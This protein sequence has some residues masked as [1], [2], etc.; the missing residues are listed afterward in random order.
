MHAHD[1]VHRDLKPDVSECHPT[2]KQSGKLTISCLKNILVQQPGPSWWVKIAD[3]GFSKRAKAD[4]EAADTYCYSP[5]FS[6]PEQRDIYS[7]E[8]CSHATDI[9]ATG[10]VTYLLLSGNLA[11]PT[12]R[13][14]RNY[15][16]PDDERYEVDRLCGPLING[17]VSPDG[18][19]FVLKLLRPHPTNRPEARLCLEDSWAAPVSPIPADSVISH[20]T[21]D[22]ANTATLGGFWGMLPL[23]TPAWLGQGTAEQNDKLAEQETKEEQPPGLVRKPSDATSGHRTL[24]SNA[25]DASRPMVSV[26]EG[27]QPE[28]LAQSGQRKTR[29]FT[30]QISA[31]PHHSLTRSQHVRIRPSYPPGPYETPLAVQGRAVST[32]TQP[33]NILEPYPTRPP[34]PYEMRFTNQDRAFTMP[35]QAQNTYG[36]ET[37]HPPQQRDSGYQSS[38]P[39]HMSPK[40]T[41]NHD[42]W[43]GVAELPAIET[44]YRTQSG[45][46]MA[47]VR[48]GS[49]MDR[50]GTGVGASVSNRHPQFTSSPR[51]SIDGPMPDCQPRTAPHV[52][53]MR[54]TPS[55]RYMIDVPM[56]VHQPRAA[57]HVQNMRDTPSPRYPIDGPT[58]NCQPRAAPHVQSMWDTPSPRYSMP[59]WQPHATPHFHSMQDTPSPKG[60]FDSLMPGFQPRAA[61]HVQ[62]MQGT[63]SPK[64]SFDNLSPGP[65]P[66][67]ARR[68]R[69]RVSVS[70]R[71]SAIQWQEQIQVGLSSRSVMA[72]TLCENGKYG[73]SWSQ[74]GILRL[75]SPQDGQRRG[76]FEIKDVKSLLFSPGSN[77]LAVRTKQDLEMYMMREYPFRLI[78]RVPINGDHA[79]EQP[80]ASECLF[81]RD[82]QRIAVP[83]ARKGGMQLINTAD[84]IVFEK[85]KSSGT[86]V[87]S[88]AISKDL[89]SLAVGLDDNTVKI[90]D[91]PGYTERHTLH[92][93]AWSL[94]QVTR[95]AYSDTGLLAASSTSGI[96]KIWDEAGHTV[97]SIPQGCRLLDCAFCPTPGSNL[98]VTADDGG[99]IRFFNSTDAEVYPNHYVQHKEYGPVLR[100]LFSPDGTFGVSCGYKTIE[101]WHTATATVL[102]RSQPQSNEGYGVRAC[103][104]PTSLNILAFALE[105]GVQLLDLGSLRARI[106]S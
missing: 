4:S 23:L 17:K 2:R 64:G 40:P 103:F 76:Q 47:D 81:S 91:L 46:N 69:S 70:P 99:C 59:D 31:V 66:H 100:V 25:G 51:E 26:R 8:R 38:S 50:W 77:I 35:T 44:P 13:D 53:S 105:T 9:F 71:S 48:S 41:E 39:L 57:P 16:D 95:V 67:T 106:P 21:S 56:P 62:S 68:I 5:G 42:A 84:G 28:T 32:P 61:P 27:P 85:L 10:L 24:T 75:W 43:T 104:S 12:I 87:T 22:T 98:V 49:P 45:N 34:K 52:Q 89:H 80:F 92:H 6:A 94:A 83:V 72:L 93:H 37:T 29:S 11:F 73:A 36:P 82:N 19:K 20:E 78:R 102:Y 63:P 30:E 3:F 74:D 65:L 79:I 54:D 58:Q 15:C 1:F 60:S 96:L 90:W 101:V 86:S 18:I 7:E 97:E 14:L 88:I 55:P 33:P